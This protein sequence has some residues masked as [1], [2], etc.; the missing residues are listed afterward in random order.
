MA[1]TAPMPRTPVATMSVGRSNVP[2]AA[3]RPASSQRRSSMASSV[4]AA[5]AMASGSEYNM[6]N[7]IAPGNRQNS[8]TARSATCRSPTLA[9]S[10]HTSS[11]AAAP[12]RTLVTSAP[13]R[14]LPPVTQ[15]ASQTSAGRPGKNAGRYGYGGAGT[16]G[17][18]VSAECQTDGRLTS[19]KCGYPCGTALGGKTSRA[20]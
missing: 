3:S 16:G 5:M 4:A 13:I 9:A 11:A 1:A 17:L 8:T 6:P 20:G 19:S 14:K 10:I 2:A 18:Y 12:P 15:C 7:V